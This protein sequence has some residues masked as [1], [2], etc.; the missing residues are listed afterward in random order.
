MV[1]GDAIV[2]TKVGW[3]G[4]GCIV[5]GNRPDGGGTPVN[6]EGP[7]GKAGPW[8]GGKEEGHPDDHHPI[9]MR[10]MRW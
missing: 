1:C 6:E 2:I 5:L 9:E 4:G 7:A 10:L 8:E 3:Y